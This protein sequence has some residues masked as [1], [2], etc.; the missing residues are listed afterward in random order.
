MAS[1]TVENYCKA[2][3]QL[4][5]RS[6]REWIATGQLAAHLGVSPGSVTSMLKVL[7]GSDLVEYRPYEGVRL[8]RSGRGLALRMVRRH[9]LIELFLVRTLGVPWD[10][11]HEEA[12]QMEHAVSDRLID[13]I[14][15]FLGRPEYDPHGDPI[16]AQNG[17]LRGHAAG[18]FALTECRGGETV[19]LARVLDQGPEFLRYLT[20][21][22]LQLGTEVAVGT[23]S[24]EAGIVSVTTGSGTVSLGWPAAGQILVEVIG[25]S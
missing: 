5:Q 19:R 6:G 9:R 10:E 12:E 4:G 7:A 13:R 16:P 18:A 17:E 23:P 24:R 15:E 22:G 3:F 8:T 20:D 25:S 21:A 2:I 11:V 14:D 1:F